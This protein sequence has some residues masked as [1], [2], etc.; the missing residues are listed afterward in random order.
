MVNRLILGNQQQGCILV[1][2]R[3][4]F[5]VILNSDVGQVTKTH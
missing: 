5:T 2:V 1:L 4:V 3:V